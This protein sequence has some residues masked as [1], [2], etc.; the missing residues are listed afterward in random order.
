[1]RERS[2]DV[3]DQASEVE[4]RFTTSAL[5]FHKANRKETRVKP[6]GACYTCGEEFEDVDSPKLF[7]NGVCARNY[8]E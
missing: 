4:E 7:C 8:S 6:I 2:S 5:E 1:M 3:I